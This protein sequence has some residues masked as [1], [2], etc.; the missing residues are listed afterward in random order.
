[1]S[2][3]LPAFDSPATQTCGSAD[4]SKSPCRRICG[5]VH[6]SRWTSLPLLPMRKRRAELEE[7]L[8]AVEMMTAVWELVHR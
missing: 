8:Q 7:A 1:M 3:D 5:L 2:E 6:C 4:V